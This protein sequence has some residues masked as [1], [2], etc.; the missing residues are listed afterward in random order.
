MTAVDARILLVEDDPSIR[1]VV[2]LGL[3]G[4]GLHGD[5][6]C[7]RRGGLARWRADGPDLVLLD[8]MLPRLD[9]L[10]VCRAIRRESTTPIVMLTARAD[11]ID[12]VVGLEAGAD[13]YVRKPFE[14][15]EL[16]ARV[17]A[18][19]RRQRDEPGPG[20]VAVLHLGPLR[21]DT[22]GRTVE[23]EGAEIVLTRTEFD[24][25]VELA[26]HPGQVL[27][28]GRPA[29]PGLGLRLPRRLAP[30]G[31][32]GRPAPDQGGGRPGEP[33]AG[34][35]GARRGLQGP[36][37]GRVGATA[38][39]IG[40]RTRIALTLV[41]LVAVTV[42]AIGLGVY[43]FV[44]ASLRA[45]LIADARQQVD[46][47]LSVLL[48]G[49]DPRPTDART[50]EA[51]GLPTAFALR[52]SGRV[53]ADFGDGSPYEPPR[54]AGA[55][56]A[57]SPELR[58]IV[59][60]RGAGLRVAGPG[61]AN[62]SSWSAVAR[63]DP[64]TCSSCSP[65]TPS[66]TRSPSSGLGLLAGGAVAIGIALLVAWVI[67]RWLL[68]PVAEAGRAA[69]RIAG[70]DLSAR[71]PERRPRRG[72]PVGR[73]VQP[74]GGL[75]RGDDRAP[76][77]PRSSRTGGSWPTS[78]TSCGRRSRRS[79]R[80]RRCSSRI[81]A[82]CRRRPAVPAELL[83]G[84][85]RRLRTLVDD[86]MEISRFDAGAELLATEPVD[87]GR[88]VTGAVAARLPEAAVSLP[89]T[90][91]VVDSD[92]R[93]LDRILGNLLD[94]ARDHA[95]GAPVEV[96]LQATRDGAVIVVADRGPGIPGDAH[97]PPLR[98]LLQGGPVA[99]GR[100]L[101]PGPRDR[102]GA[103]GAARR[104]AARPRPPRRRDGLR[105]DPARDRI[106]TSGRCA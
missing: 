11:T 89:P 36:P 16:V 69:R 24:L 22:A 58:T 37:I 51:S 65:R 8:V 1:E 3:R 44:D 62:R 12:V 95:P 47:N 57:V 45:R 94:N 93:R 77:G 42:A 101:R 29:G 106:V 41:A 79:S 87:L 96:A 98:A 10:E 25:L 72:G 97:P 83:V 2:A 20:E 54:L 35:H 90:P 50:F 81:W 70:G 86:L 68:R 80:R 30:G 82:A 91:L 26:R 103:R 104:L 49:A 6:G 53:L 78:P 4:G 31:R 102:G 63:A 34:P 39:A 100:K 74:D 48:P 15:P 33:A 60:R 13:D 9:G 7:R 55:L 67:A 59:S 105:A 43:A 23:R 40:I 18:A 32:G 19:L 14:M 64:R 71:V 84:D 28:P 21:I 17:R 76:R 92:P 75:A 73:R 61:A 88:V 52:G 99:G 46:Y 38:V 5:D 85:V 66:R 27:D 56:A